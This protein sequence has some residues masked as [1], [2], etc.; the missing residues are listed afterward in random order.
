MRKTVKLNAK[1]RCSLLINQQR[2]YSFLEPL[3]FV[4]QTTSAIVCFYF[5]KILVNVRIVII[6]Q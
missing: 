1:Q 5:L 6:S 2:Y 4:P 3:S